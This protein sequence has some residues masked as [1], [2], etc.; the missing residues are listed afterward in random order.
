MTGTQWR[1]YRQNDLLLHWSSLKLN[2]LRVVKPSVQLVQL[3][4][5]AGA[6]DPF[7]QGVQVSPSAMEPFRQ[8]A[9]NKQGHGSKKGQRRPQN[10]QGLPRTECS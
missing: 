8:A 2:V 9:G 10:L 6:Q 5:L 7:A 4:A 1:G 3:E